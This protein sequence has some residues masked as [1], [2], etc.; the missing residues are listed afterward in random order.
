MK[1]GTEISS[2]ITNDLMFWTDNVSEPKKINIQRSIQGSN[3]EGTVPTKL[4]VNDED[5]G[6][7]EEKHVRVIKERP[8]NTLSLDLQALPEAAR[9]EAKTDFLVDFDGTD[10]LIQ[11]GDTFT[12][13]INPSNTKKFKLNKISAVIVEFSFIKSFIPL[14][15]ISLKSI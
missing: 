14:L 15:L 2:D 13:T 8:Y 9:G 5:L 6:F 7:V 12:V 10:R 4:I 11:I 3:I 1:K